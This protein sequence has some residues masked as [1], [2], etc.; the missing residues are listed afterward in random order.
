MELL[1]VILIAFFV[2]MLFSLLGLG[3]AIIYTPLFYWSG[4]DLLTAIPMALFLNMITTASSSITY[5]KQ[6]MVEMGIAL[7]II[8]ASIPGAFMGSMIARIID[9]ELLIFLLSICILFAGIRILFFE[10]RRTSVI[11]ARNRA[12]AGACAGFAISM[13]SS[14][15]GIGGGTFIVPLLLVFG[16]ETK[17]A[18]GTSSLIVS[19]ISLSGFLSHISQGG[20]QIDI[21]ILVFA[22]TA[23]FAGAQAGSRLI[24]RQISPRTIERI[25]ALVL[26]FVGGKLLYGILL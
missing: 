15:V 17:K 14:M 21:S 26:L 11:T 22:G 19:F 10:I 24:F 1:I 5:L 6:R 4:L 13:V 18:V 12:A 2:A 23:A 9:I 7:P 20:Q 3:G 25:F 8:I 16:L